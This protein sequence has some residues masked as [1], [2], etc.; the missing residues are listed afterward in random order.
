M[1]DLLLCQR[2]A[3]LSSNPIILKHLSL[4]QEIELRYRK[5]TSL[6]ISNLMPDNTLGNMAL[7]GTEGGY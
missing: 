7:T 1:L 5:G 2:V 4:S 6:A 3:L